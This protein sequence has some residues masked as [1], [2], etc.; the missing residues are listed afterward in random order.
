MPCDRWMHSLAAAGETPEPKVVQAFAVDTPVVTVD[1]L[2]VRFA[3]TGE[4]ALTGVSF[5]VPAGARLAITGPNG[6]GKS[7]LARCLTGLVTPLAG[8]VRINGRDIRQFDPATYRSGIGF[9]PQEPGVFPLSIAEHIRLVQPGWE[10]AEIEAAL[11][12]ILGADWWRTLGA[13]QAEGALAHVMDPAGRGAEADRASG[14]MGLALAAVGDPPFSILD[15]PVVDRDPVLDAALTRVLDRT[16][17]RSTMILTTHRPEL[18]RSADLVLV[19]DHGAIA[20]F[21]RVKSA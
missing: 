5:E 18:I 17:G 16:R 6:S 10:D 11:V 21:G 19:L 3:G 20:H 9:L 7:V 14:A 2:F 15:N 13:P 8:S 12:S 1:R 4:P